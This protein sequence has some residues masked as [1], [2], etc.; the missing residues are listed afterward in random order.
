M[1]IYSWIQLIRTGIK[2]DLERVLSYYVYA[3]ITKNR[4]KYKGKIFKIKSIGGYDG[5]SVGLTSAE[6]VM[7]RDFLQ[8][9]LNKLYRTLKYE[10]GNHV[11]EYID[12]HDFINMIKIIT[13]NGILL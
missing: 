2:K 12:I 10:F 13:N 8:V 5:I 11:P 1:M 9:D 7:K 6:H 4:S 3:D